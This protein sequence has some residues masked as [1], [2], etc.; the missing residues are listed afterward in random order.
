MTENAFITDVTI[1][2]NFIRCS[3]KQQQQK[4]LAFQKCVGEKRACE[5]FSAAFIPKD[6]MVSLHTLSSLPSQ[7]ILHP[8]E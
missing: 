7:A 6:E 2:S 5:D 1:T 8:L 4:C 3:A